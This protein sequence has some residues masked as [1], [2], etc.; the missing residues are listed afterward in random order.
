MGFAFRRRK[1]ESVV[2]YWGGEVAGRSEK[3]AT[4]PLEI[5]IIMAPKLLE[6]VSATPQKAIL[7]SLFDHFL[8]QGSANASYVVAL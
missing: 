8:F 1:D 7:P 5:I 2:G 4:H 3:I 6:A